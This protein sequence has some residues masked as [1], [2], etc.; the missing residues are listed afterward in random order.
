[1]KTSFFFTLEQLESWLQ[2]AAEDYK[3]A[4]NLEFPFSRETVLTDQDV[5]KILGVCEKTIR[6]YR[7]EHYI[8][9]VE[10]SKKHYY[11]RPLL[12]MDFLRLYY[13]QNGNG[14][15]TEETGK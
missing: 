1:M 8:H 4:S 10:L 3:K 5:M 13:E 14:K 9:S 6:K 11:L 2:Q 15:E 7:R 12:F